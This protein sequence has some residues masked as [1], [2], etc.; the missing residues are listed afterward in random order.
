MSRK[1]FPTVALLGVLCVSMSA[2]VVA[3]D[4]K[5][6]PAL[7]GEKKTAVL[8]A[9]APPFI[10]LTSA[11]QDPKTPMRLK[12]AKGEK[13]YV[14]MTMDMEMKMSTKQG[15]PLPQQKLPGQKLTILISVSDVASSG[16]VSFKVTI[17]KSEVVS[18]AGVNPQIEAHMA[19]MIK[20]IAGYSADVVLSSRGAVKSYKPNLKAGLD[21]MAKQALQGMEDNFAAIAI[22]FPEEAIGIGA[23]WSVTRP[24]KSQGIEMTRVDVYELTKFEGGAGTV[25]VTSKQDAKPQE[26][27]AEGA[28]PGVK[29]RVI[30]MVTTGTG[31]NSFSLTKIAPKT[32]SLTSATDAEMEAEFAGQKQEMLLEMKVVQ[33]TAE[34]TAPAPDPKAAGKALTPGQVQ[35][36]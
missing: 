13:Q 18:K 28:P 9:K 12:V 5:K 2:Q 27:K 32:S 24:V 21:A 30:K 15:F 22:P 6:A 11:G 35:T 34:T 25:K 19:R 33:K 17:V 23:K 26:V 3:Q 31:S 8:T 4:E 20:T 10:K 7:D 29:Q 16:D 36:Q 1:L 14:T